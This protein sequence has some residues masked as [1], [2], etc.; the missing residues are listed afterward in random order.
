MPQG[1]LGV[2]EPRA[3]KPPRAGHCRVGERLMAGAVGIDL[4]EVP[5]GRPELVQ[6]VN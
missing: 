6:V 5:D 3:G 2:I 1:M 4:V